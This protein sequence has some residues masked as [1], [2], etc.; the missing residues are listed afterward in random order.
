MKNDLGIGLFCYNRPSH[1]KRVLIALEDLKIKDLVIFIDG[2]LNQL[3]Q[4]NHEPLVSRLYIPYKVV[5]C[6]LP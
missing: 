6:F 1:L 3:D 5:P 4:I 2:P